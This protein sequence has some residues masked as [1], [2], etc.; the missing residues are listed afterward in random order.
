MNRNDII[1]RKFS[2]AFFGYDVTDVDLFL[3]EIIREMDRVHNEL[4]IETLKAEAARRREEKLK[5]RM[6]LM[7]KLL[8]DAGIE[9]DTEALFAVDDLEADAVEAKT[10]AEN[11]EAENT[12]A[13]NTEAEEPFADEASNES[14]AD[15]ASEGSPEA[16]SSEAAEREEA[17]ESE[18]EK[19]EE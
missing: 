14:A 11:A 4:D 19:T 7:G 8:E 9:V 1:K 18:E 15:M 3:D 6:L 10:E 13:E 16:E 2:H 17:D 12:E 5:E